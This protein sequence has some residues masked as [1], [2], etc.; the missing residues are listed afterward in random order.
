MKVG[1]Q[2]PTNCKAVNNFWNRGNNSRIPLSNWTRFLY[3]RQTGASLA[4]SSAKS[5]LSN[6]VDLQSLQSRTSILRIPDAAGFSESRDASKRLKIG[7][8]ND[9]LCTYL[10][11]HPVRLQR[12]ILLRGHHRPHARMSDSDASGTNMS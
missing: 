5:R 11:P 10:W 1:I 7:Q 3:A 4:K 6:N 9:R 8:L 12:S 2:G